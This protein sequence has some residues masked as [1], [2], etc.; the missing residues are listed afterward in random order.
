MLS[1]LRALPIMVDAESA[2]RAATA[3]FARAAGV[4]LAMKA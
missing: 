3:T 4:P 2:L 1:A